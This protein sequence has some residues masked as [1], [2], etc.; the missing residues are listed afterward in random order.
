LNSQCVAVSSLYLTDGIDCGTDY[1]N[2]NSGAVH[3]GSR[4]SGIIHFAFADGSVR[5]IQNTSS[6]N[7]GPMFQLML[8]LG[9][10]RDNDVVTAP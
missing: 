10:I 6:L 3:F 1:L 7:E 4:H 9:G 8:S 5:G 2:P